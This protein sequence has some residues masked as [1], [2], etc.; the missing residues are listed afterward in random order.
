[1]AASRLRT[2]PL[3]FPPVLAS[4]SRSYVRRDEARLLSGKRKRILRSHLSWMR[5]VSKFVTCMFY[6]D[7]VLRKC[8]ELTSLPALP[9][10]ASTSHA[11]RPPSLLVPFSP[12]YVVSLTPSPSCSSLLHLLDCSHYLSLLTSTLECRLCC[13]PRLT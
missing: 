9:P 12:I 8:E 5:H 13:L 11:C 4:M 10:Y 1:M 2:L 6:F 3:F 7:V